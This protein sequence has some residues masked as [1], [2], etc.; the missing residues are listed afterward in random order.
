MDIDELYTR[1][2]KS[3]PHAERRRLLA[4]M[5]RDLAHEDRTASRAYS[6]LELEGLGAEL[7][8]EDDA[9]AY[10]HALRDEWKSRL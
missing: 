8:Q 1:H 6:L 10:V 9:Q 3:L 5:T 2:I 7:W 4:R